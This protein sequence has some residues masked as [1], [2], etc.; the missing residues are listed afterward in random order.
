MTLLEA[1]DDPNL[2]RAWFRT[3]ETWKAW[4]SFLAALFGLPMSD[5]ELATY[6]ACTA[7]Q[8]AP[9]TQAREAWL[10]C[11]RRGGKSFMM[12]LIAV[13][14]AAFKE[15]RQFLAPGEKATILLIAADRRQGRV[16]LRY[17]GGLLR[18]VPMLSRMIGRETSEG[19]DLTNDAVIEVSAGNFRTVRGYS[20]ACAICDEIAYWRS[21]DSA[22]PDKEVL[23]ALRPALLTLPNSLIVAASSPYRRA[24]VL[25]DA[26]QRHYGHDGS[27]LVWQ[28]PTRTMNPSIAQEEIDA[29]YEADPAAAAA[30][31]GALFRSDLQAFVD[32]DALD[33]CVDV[34]CRERPPE[35]RWAYFPFCD[36]SGGA[37]DTMSIGIAHKEGDKTVVLDLI[38]ERKPPFSPESVVEEFAHILKSYKL[39][40]V[41]GDRYSGEWVREAFSR[42]DI[43]YVHSG[44]TRSEIYQ[45]TLPLINSGILALLDD[46]KL[47]TQI[48]TLERR[49]SGRG[50]D[51]IDHP[52][53]GHDD[54]ANA[55][56]GALDLAWTRGRG[57]EKVRLLGPPP[58]PKFSDPLADFR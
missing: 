25:W 23:A 34:G 18:N 43:T 2:F 31:Y 44:K 33:A 21:E 55:A 58:K 28:A 17:V 41:T 9:T 10:I 14:V 35:R 7:R 19:F 32:R 15:H 51:V 56:L 1:L 57:T 4:R 40:K 24:G 29:A 47:I 3:P 20:L 46:R 52:P 37:V 38:R 39:T 50:R 48:G 12:A 49:T 13:F 6:R 42:R 16:V 26:R 22:S 5:E 11:G 53:G 45:D 36:P 30:E 8:H 54:L 27:V